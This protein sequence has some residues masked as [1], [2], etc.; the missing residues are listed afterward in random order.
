[1][2]LEDYISSDK[3]SD[4]AWALMW[5][6]IE[7]GKA[8]MYREGERVFAVESDP[9]TDPDKR[10][11]RWSIYWHKIGRRNLRHYRG[12][13]YF[14]TVELAQGVLNSRAAREGWECI[15]PWG[16]GEKPESH[17]QTE[18]KQPEK[19]QQMELFGE[20]GP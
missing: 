17:G 9:F 3:A 18:E 16:L 10:D 15:G 5:R 19:P 14:P 4:R 6:H 8:L 20:G 11:L 1:M 13:R 2:S 7:S 12:F